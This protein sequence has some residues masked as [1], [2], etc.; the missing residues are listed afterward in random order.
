MVTKLAAARASAGGGPRSS[1]KR[2]PRVSARQGA[3][4]FV[5][6]PAD[7]GSSEAVGWHVD[8][9]PDAVCSR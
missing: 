6:A 2:L 4:E 3:G 9:R 7:P 1:L 5:S 8:L